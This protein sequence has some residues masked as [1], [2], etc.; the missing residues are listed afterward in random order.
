M[1]QRSVYR[2]P[3]VDETVTVNPGLLEHVRHLPPQWTRA[4]SLKGTAEIS[5]REFVIDFAAGMATVDERLAHI[6]VE[7]GIATAEKAVSRVV[8]LTAP[9][10]ARPHCRPR[11]LR[12][13]LTLN[14]ACCWRGVPR[15]SA[16]WIMGEATAASAKSAKERTPTHD[17]R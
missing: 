4:Y 6:L 5:C 16:M 17:R 15:P 11:L 14:L 13:D 3:S 12:T 8:P 2:H 10:P 9:L 7:R 1:K